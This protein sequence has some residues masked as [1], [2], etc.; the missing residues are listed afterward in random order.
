MTSSSGL[1]IFKKIKTGGHFPMRWSITQQ[2]RL[3]PCCKDGFP[4]RTVSGLMWNL[5]VMPFLRLLQILK[6]PLEHAGTAQNNFY[7]LSRFVNNFTFS[8]H[9][10]MIGSSY[11]TFG[12]TPS[13]QRPRIRTIRRVHVMPWATPIRRIGSMR[14]N[15]IGQDSDDWTGLGRRWLY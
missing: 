6:R 1:F 8:R 3:P 2:R 15:C 12:Y 13:S 11:K 4:R 9:F 5:F 7:Y 14:L 10:A